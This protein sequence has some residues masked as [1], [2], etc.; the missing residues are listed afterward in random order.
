[1]KK[2]EKKYETIQI[3]KKTKKNLRY[4]HAETGKPLV[5]LI[6]ELVNRELDRITG[7]R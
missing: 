2:D 6:D 4:L 7:M 3:W 5:V 1:M